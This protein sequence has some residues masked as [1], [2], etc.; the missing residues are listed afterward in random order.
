MSRGS[1]LTRQRILD[2]ASEEFRLHGYPDASMRRIAHGAKATT[3]AIYHHFPSKELLFDA[4]VREPAEQLLSLW[5]ALHTASDNATPEAHHHSNDGTDAV[6]AFVYDHLDAF[7]LVFCHA[8]GTPYE[9]YAKRLIAVEE[10][11]YRRIPGFDGSPADDL[12]LHTAAASGV[13]ALRAAVEHDLSRNEAQ[14][15]M[16]RIK[17]FRTKGWMGLVAT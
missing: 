6:L 9:N 10:A 13:E 12:F 8:A 4:L 3:G 7:R 16:T 2:A 1:E 11:T 17:E 14:K 5:V 15:Y